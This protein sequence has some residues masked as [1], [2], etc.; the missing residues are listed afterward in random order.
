MLNAVAKLSQDFVWQIV[1]KLRAE[2]DAHPFRA[3]DTDDLLY[4]LPQDCRR[5]GKQEM[6][7]IKEER[8]LGFLEIAHFG[9]VFEQLRQ[10][11]Q[12]KAGI[13]PRFQDELV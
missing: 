4:P 8:Q 2:I 7:F 13:Q 12:E 5:I 1:R 9:K 10:E 11:P 3:D 6:G